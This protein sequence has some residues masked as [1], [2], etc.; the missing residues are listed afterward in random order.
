MVKK[1][2]FIDE[3]S[4]TSLWCIHWQSPLG[5]MVKPL[6]KHNQV[7]CWSL[8]HNV[9]TLCRHTSMLS[10]IWDTMVWLW[11]TN[12]RQ[13]MKWSQFYFSLRLLKVQTKFMSHVASPA[14]RYGATSSEHRKWESFQQ[15]FSRSVKSR[16]ISSCA[17]P[18]RWSYR[19]YVDRR[20]ETNTS[21]TLTKSFRCL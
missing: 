1:W 2:H 16:W 17:A 14:P 4:T 20:L 18:P 21:L 3:Y 12:Q 7:K 19:P 11:Q 8:Q 13:V 15:S 5:K 6:E 10:V 9:R